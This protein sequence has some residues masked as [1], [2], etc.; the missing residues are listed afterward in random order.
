M[1]AA[2]RPLDMAKWV[3]KLQLPLEQSW[4]CVQAQDGTFNVESTF[5]RARLAMCSIRITM[6]TL[7]NV[8]LWFKCLSPLLKLKETDYD[9]TKVTF[10]RC[11]W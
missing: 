4:W 3:T 5:G 11:K 2:T 6:S 10:M 7:R 1:P 8:G 9:I